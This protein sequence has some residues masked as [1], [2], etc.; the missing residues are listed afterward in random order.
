VLTHEEA[1]RLLVDYHFNRLPAEASAKIEDHI[2]SCAACQREGLGH[3]RTERHSALRQLA[4]VRPA[5]RRR[6][7]R[8]SRRGIV[9]AG[10][11]CVA[12]VVT[13]GVITHRVTLTPGQGDTLGQAPA[14]LLAAQ[15]PLPLRTSGA[16][17]V[18]A[19]PSD[20]IV[21]V[22]G[23]YSGT[24]NITLFSATDGQTIRTL[25]WPGSGVPTALAW[26]PDGTVLAAS[27]GALVADLDT[28]T[29]TP[30]WTHSAPT[31]GTASIFLARN[32]AV[33]STPNL[34][35]GLA[36]NA[37]LQWGAD[38]QL[39]PA[40]IG[41]AEPLGAASANGPLV[42]AWRARGTHFSL[43]GADVFAGMD[44]P[45][46]KSHHI[47]LDWSPDG[48]Y[49]LYSIPSQHVAMPDASGSAAQQGAPPPDA[50]LVRI[51][52]R[53]QQAK[54]GDGFA[55]FA[56][57]GKRLAV[58]DRTSTG[59]ALQ[60]YDLGSSRLI[61]ALPGVC[62]GLEVTSVAWLSHSNVLLIALPGQPVREYQAG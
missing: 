44:P 50:I 22:A 62:D 10:V 28:S 25:A 32:G 17:A 5:R 52:R 30:R 60:V 18:A 61:A 4:S 57:T 14:P 19:D 33:A 43:H 6:L 37:F 49:L 53:L 7:P 40:P 42:G 26:A 47:A 23:T 11:L 27:D 15:V 3:A 36:S 9:G 54:Q 29:P 41:A 20:H 38:G 24:P 34:T 8:S 58:C 51:L 13:L 46:A 39:I 48:R 55:W 35:D 21:A 12:V 45:A 1:L 59:A 2:R 31:S 56:G 16:A